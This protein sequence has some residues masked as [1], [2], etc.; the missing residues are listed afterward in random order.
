MEKCQTHST[1]SRAVQCCAQRSSGGVSG[2]E[3]NWILQSSYRSHTV[4][5]LSPCI[6]PL[7]SNVIVPNGTYGLVYLFL[8]YHTVLY[9]TSGLSPCIEGVAIVFLLH[10]A[11][12][13]KGPTNVP[14][15]PLSSIILFVSTQE[16][17]CQRSWI[18]LS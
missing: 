14:F 8:H 1:G 12:L 5:Y 11:Q 9:N 10:S 17:R 3:V 6:C 15:F 13:P 7:S 16:M 18:F 2:N 4:Q